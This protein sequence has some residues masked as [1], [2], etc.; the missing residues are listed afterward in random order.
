MENAYQILE[1]TISAPGRQKLA[2]EGVKS[3]V[4]KITGI[5]LTSDRPDLA[6]YAEIGLSLAGEEILPENYGADMFLDTAAGHDEKY[7][8]IDR[9]AGIEA[10]NKKVAPV[11]TDKQ[12]PALFA[13]YKI[14]IYL[15][16]EK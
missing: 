11:W 6:V 7:A 4:K 9:G 1:Y 2:E 14:K 10:A 16:C 5:T 3:W 8:L 12:D 13:A 15:R